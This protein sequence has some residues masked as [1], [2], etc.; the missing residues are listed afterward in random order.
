MQKLTSY[1]K[2][3]MSSL[4]EP[5]KNKVAKLIYKFSNDIKSRQVKDLS[6]ENLSEKV[7]INLLELDSLVNPSKYDFKRND[8]EEVTIDI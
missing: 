7:E 1:L 6:I 8:V 4:D 5:Y 2:S 3:L